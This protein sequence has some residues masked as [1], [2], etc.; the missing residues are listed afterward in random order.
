MLWPA[1]RAELFPLMSGDMAR[2][3]GAAALVFQQQPSHSG[4]NVKSQTI[5]K[6]SVR[7]SN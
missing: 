4:S 5:R 2:L 6:Y 1:R 7:A 3:R